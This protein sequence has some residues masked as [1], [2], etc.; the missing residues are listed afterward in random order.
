MSEIDSNYL[1]KMIS[2]AGDGSLLTPCQ[3]FRFFSI[4][5]SFRRAVGEDNP[6][7]RPVHPHCFPIA[8]FRLNQF[9]LDGLDHRLRS[10]P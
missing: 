1:P 3:P 9:Q 2:E 10:Y 8:A 5:C 4:F 6:P 7:S